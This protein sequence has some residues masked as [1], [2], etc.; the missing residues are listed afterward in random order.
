[1]IRKDAKGN[2]EITRGDYLPITLNTKDRFGQPY[3]FQVGDIIRISITKKS[4][5]DEVVLRKDFTVT[6]PS[7]DFAIELL[8]E[9]TRIG[10]VISKP[11]TYWYDVELNPD[12]PE[13]QTIIG[14]T[15]PD[16][17][18]TITLTPESGKGGVVNG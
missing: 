8:S 15:V 12:S 6:E 4:D 10:D 17:P 16:G 11:V 3:T 13:A 1:M 7:K 5:C 2:I 18:K 9:E 14:Y